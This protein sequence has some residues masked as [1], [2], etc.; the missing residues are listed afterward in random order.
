MSDDIAGPAIEVSERI[1]GPSIEVPEEIAGPSIEVSE[2]IAEP[3]I[4]RKKKLERVFLI[5]LTLSGIWFCQSTF[6]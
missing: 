6:E 1:P 2:T 5:Q 4:G 3:S